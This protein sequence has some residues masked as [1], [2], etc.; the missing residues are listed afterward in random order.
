VIDVDFTEHFPDIQ[1]FPASKL[2]TASP[3]PFLPRLRLMKT[4]ERR[5]FRDA[6]DGKSFTPMPT[7]ANATSLFGIC[8]T[9][10]VFGMW[11]FH[12][13]EGRW[14]REVLRVWLFPKSSGS[15]WKS[16]ARQS[17]RID[18]LQIQKD[19]GLIYEAQGG[20]WTLD[21]AKAGKDK[22]G[23]PVK[24]GKEGKPSEAKPR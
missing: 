24:L 16:A 12:R 14:W 4:T 3:T 17:S 19:S 22:S 7:L 21:P 2:P 20:G 6:P 1:R 23:K 8:P 18:P 5:R 13:A 15:T 9:A 10:L 11:E